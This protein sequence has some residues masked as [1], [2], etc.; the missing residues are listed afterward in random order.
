M[1]SC[2]N[3]SSQAFCGDAQTRGRSRSPLLE[4]YTRSIFSQGEQKIP[5]EL[6]P[7]AAADRSW[8]VRLMEKRSKKEDEKLSTEAGQVQ[9]LLN[10]CVERNRFAVRRAHCAT[11][12]TANL[13]CAES[14][15]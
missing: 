1:I 5:S 8:G 12:L 3:R 2:V 4:L 7:P 9:F 14:G 6:L 15:V 10:G 13:T 11:P